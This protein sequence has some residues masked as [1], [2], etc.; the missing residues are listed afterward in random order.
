MLNKP[1]K[2]LLSYDF[3]VLTDTFWILTIHTISLLFDIIWKLFKLGSLQSQVI[4][5]I[6]VPMRMDLEQKCG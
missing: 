4:S 2:L 5:K 6:F 3:Y 1:F